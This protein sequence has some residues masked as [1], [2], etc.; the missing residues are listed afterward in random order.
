[1]R[2]IALLFILLFFVS[3]NERNLGKDYYCLSEYEA[4]EY[5]TG[6]FVYKSFNENVFEKIIVYPKVKN[7][8]FN[9]GYIIVFQQPDKQIMLKEI[10]SDITFWNNYYLRNKKDSLISLIHGKIT[11]KNI[12]NLIKKST[13]KDL[14]KVADS[15]FKNELF[16]KKM[17]QNKSNYYI[18]EK[19]ND[20]VFG[21]LTVKEFEILKRNKKIDLDF[22]K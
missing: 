3:C 6:S 10:K 11:L 4:N 20:S 2:K 19:A 17:F 22:E 21:P 5:L 18:I 12:N 16:Y 9:K 13:T 7:I 14:N 1:M 8:E 15:I